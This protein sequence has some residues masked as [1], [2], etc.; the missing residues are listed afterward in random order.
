[1]SGS[2]V[3]YSTISDGSMKRVGEDTRTVDQNRHRF[4]LQYD[5]NPERSVLVQLSYDSGNFCRYDVVDESAAGEGMVRPGRIADGL[6][7]QK[8]NLALFLPL[9][10]CNG[11]VLYDPEHAA[12]MVTH[13][14]RHNLEQRGGQHSVEFMTHQFSADPS[15]LHAYFSPHAGAERY[16]L[17]AFDG[18]SI[19]DISRDQLVQ[20]GLRHDNIVDAKIDTTDDD[21]YYSHSEFL[22]GNQQSDGRFAV[23]AMLSD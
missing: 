10:D 22:K 6:A 9:A 21:R 19:G 17:Y 11:V 14:G 2:R 16:P 7:T 8:K 3:V 1:M 15:K 12:I 4:L 5:T 23:L 13:L 18:R 20:A